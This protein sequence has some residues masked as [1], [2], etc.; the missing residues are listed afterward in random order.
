MIFHLFLTYIRAYLQMSCLADADVSEEDKIKAVMNQ[1]GYDSMNYKC[2]NVLPA[3]YTCYRCGN[4]GHH[5]RNCPHSK[6]KNADTPVRIKKSTGIPRSFLVEVD[7]PSIKGAMLTNCG[8]FAIP[9]IDAEAYAISK[10]E[11]PAFVQDNPEEPKD[12][13]EPVPQEL[14]CLICCDLLSEAVVIP[15]CANSYCDDCIRSALLDSDEHVCPTCHTPEVSPDTLIA[16]KFLR[17]AV[18]NYKKALGGTTSQKKGSLD[19]SSQNL[20]LTPSPTV[21]PPTAF[22]Q[23]QL[24]KPQQS[25]KSQQD[26]L[27]YCSKAADTSTSSQESETPPVAVGSASASNTPSRSPETVQLHLEIT[28]EISDSAAASLLDPDLHTSAPSQ[29]QVDPPQ[30]VVVNQQKSP[31]G[32]LSEPTPQQLLPSSSSSYP[33]T[34]SSSINP[35]LPLSGYPPGYPPAKPV[36]TFP[37]PKG[38]PTSSLCSSSIP[39]LIPEWHKNQR[40]KTERS[41]HR[42]S[43]YRHSSK[44]S[45]SKSSHSYP[46]SRSRSR[47]RSRSKCRSRESSNSRSKSS[48]FKSSHSHLSSGSRSRSRSRSRPKDRSRPHSPSSCRRDQHVR[49]HSS[50]SYSYGYKRVHSPTTSSSSSP[51]ASHHSRHKSPSGH[52]H[53]RKKSATSSSRSKTGGGHHWKQGGS[54]ER[55]AGYTYPQYADQMSSFKLDTQR[56]LQWRE[57]YKNW[58]EKYLSSYMEHFHQLP[59]V[60][61]CL[62]SSSGDEEKSRT[63]SRDQHQGRRSSRTHCCSPA[64]QTSTDS[65][66]LSYQSSSDGSSKSSPSSSD[67]SSSPSRS[68]KN[69]C[70][71][72]SQSSSDSRSARPDSQ[73]EESEETAVKAG[74]Q[75]GKLPIMKTLEDL[76]HE[77]HEKMCLKQHIQRAGDESDLILS[78]IH[79]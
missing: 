34:P 10:K 22:P 58:C 63:H 65:C 9:A 62:F 12:E 26:P 11:K 17:Q 15:C 20:S 5:I 73:K 52:R 3:N 19:S 61:P 59:P 7:D 32:S 77:E 72:S 2:G 16:N 51:R 76:S 4:T 56:Y 45:R 33:S 37:T 44:S 54:M 39:S 31:S 70:S 64:S 27:L 8:R 25:I 43:S 28:E 60:P 50:Q 46:S 6:D 74:K 75:D 41:P 53:H 1:S 66:S 23:N 38:A 30:A 35:F 18:N 47:S 48:K 13:Q 71:P 29:P 78:L 49:P 55:S 14:S 40:E 36:W 57:E 21:T 68:S 67:M 79:I 69:S 42:G 24:L